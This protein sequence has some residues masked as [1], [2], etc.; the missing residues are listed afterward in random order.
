[1]SLEPL[2][3]EFS[4]VQETA[5]HIG[6]VVHA[7]LERLASASSLPTSEDI[8]AQLDDFAHQLRRLG[9]PERDIE[10]GARTVTQ[11][12]TRTLQH[13]EGRWLLSSSHRE[14][15]SE[16]ALTGIADGHLTNVIID[17]TF[18]DE[19]GT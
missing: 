11:A 4:W 9:V 12:L 1:R 3:P 19:S 14:A 16:L 2:S 13:E 8:A 17:R 18:I 10:R 7:A 5:R 6:T 15:R